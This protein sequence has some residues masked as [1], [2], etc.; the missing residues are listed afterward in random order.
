MFVLSSPT[1]LN[2]CRI[3]VA[4][5]AVSLCREQGESL[6]RKRQALKREEGRDTFAGRYSVFSLFDWQKRTSSAS[7]HD[8]GDAGTYV[9]SLLSVRIFFYHA[10]CHCDPFCV[11]V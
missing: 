6:A 1:P 8:E 3:C 11:F 7:P 2:S 10:K 5:V 4:L 9:V